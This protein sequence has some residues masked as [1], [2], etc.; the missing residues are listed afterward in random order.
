MTR[1]L[2]LVAIGIVLAV[3]IGLPLALLASES[4]AEGLRAGETEA[5]VNTGLLALGSAAVAALTGVPVGWVAARRRLPRALEAALVLPYAVPPY[6]TTIAWILLANPTNGILTAWLPINAYTLVGMIGV[7]GLHL[8][9]VVALATRDALGRVDPVLEEAARVAGASAWRTTLSISLPLTL[10]AVG[11]AIAFVASAAAASFGVPY[12]LGASASPPVPVLT[13]RIY[14]AL[15][16]APVE[17]RPLAVGLS[18]VLLGV[19]VALPAML[20]LLQGQRAYASARLARPRPLPPAGPLALVVYA[21]LFVAVLLPVGTIALTSVAPIFGHFDAFT[22][23]HWRAVLAEPRSRGAL[24]RSTILAAAAATAAVGIGALLAHTAER[25]PSRAVSALVALARAPWAVPGTVM[26]LGMILAFSQEIRVIVLDRA[27]FA[28]ALADTSWLLGIAY[29]AKS[30]AVPLDGVRAAVRTVDRSLEEAAR[31]SGASWAQTQLRVVLPLLTPAMLAGWGLV[32]AASF[33]EVSMSILLRGP[34]TE[35]LG[36]RLFELLSY[37]SPQ[38]AAVIA[39]IV[40]VA[41]LV[42]A[43]AIAWRA[44]WA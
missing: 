17:G 6:V 26:A 35:V 18:L 37:G 31:I 2:V 15:E 38:Q 24:L 27:T 11:A 5:L 21:W 14:R 29:A 20:R 30:L 42:G 34:G 16:L 32:F 43:R 3:F 41:V 39:M 4:S 13:L 40:V 10:P 25:A 23:E 36:T 28:L 12:L 1:R 33:C 8:S 9:P 22:L 7:L 19:G 44:R